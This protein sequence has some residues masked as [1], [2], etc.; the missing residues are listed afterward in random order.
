MRLL[1]LDERVAYHKCLFEQ[2]KVRR[3]L[4]VKDPFSWVSPPTC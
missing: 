3:N 1:G 4:A 2:M